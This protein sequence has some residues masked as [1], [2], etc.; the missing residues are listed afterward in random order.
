MSA[1][2]L[3]E[4]ILFALENDK[5]FIKSIDLT[6]VTKEEVQHRYKQN[7]ETIAKQAVDKIVVH[8]KKFSI[9]VDRV[10]VE[11]LIQEKD[12]DKLAGP[13]LH[14]MS[15]DILFKSY[16]GRKCVLLNGKKKSSI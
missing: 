10:K 8:E 9:F 16:E 5:D 12:F 2:A 4:T 15:I 6:G 14:E 13:N 1:K 11:S 3:D 7:L